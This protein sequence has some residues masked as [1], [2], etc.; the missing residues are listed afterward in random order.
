MRL[1]HL[2]L[3]VS[4]VIRAVGWFE[5]LFGF[6]LQSNRSSPAIAILTDRHGFVLVLQRKRDAGQ[7]YPE[8]FHIGFLVDDV[9]TV[10][11]FHERARGAGFEVSDVQQNSRGTL[12]Y[13]KTPEGFLVE[14]SVRR[15]SP[16]SS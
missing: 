2:D 12:V 6:E 11:R 16:A 3:Q 5:D 14:V 8:G 13:W 7:G 10:L 4:D 1:N 15:R 9:E